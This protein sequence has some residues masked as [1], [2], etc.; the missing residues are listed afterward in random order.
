M[1]ASFR[2]PPSP[3]GPRKAEIRLAYGH[4][5]ARAVSPLLS[6]D[7]KPVS[8][9]ESSGQLDDEE[10]RVGRRESGGDFSLGEL[11]V[12]GPTG[13]G[14]LDRSGGVQIEQLLGR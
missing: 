5:A 9:V 10:G 13:D 8:E 3:A 14:P 4:A 2:G 12:V 1:Q 11:V 7:E 6:R